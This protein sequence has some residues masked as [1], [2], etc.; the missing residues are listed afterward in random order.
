MSSSCSRRS[1]VIVPAEDSTGS[2]SA[3]RCSISSLCD[4]SPCSP[5]L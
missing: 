1:R 3:R 2:P 4:W 5:E